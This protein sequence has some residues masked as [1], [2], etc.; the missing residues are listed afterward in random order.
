MPIKKAVASG[1][2]NRFFTQKLYVQIANKPQVQ[3]L[4]PF[5]PTSFFITITFKIKDLHALV[6]NFSFSEKEFSCAKR[7]NTC[8]FCSRSNILMRIFMQIEVLITAWLLT[9]NT[10]LAS[11]ERRGDAG[12]QRTLQ[13]H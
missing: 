11:Y 4:S 3:L 13:S 9:N 12:P 5:Q 7:E 1:N 6:E 10:V 8:F 2:G